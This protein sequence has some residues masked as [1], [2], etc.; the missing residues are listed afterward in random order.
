MSYWLKPLFLKL[1]D[2]GQDISIRIAHFQVF[3]IPLIEF[4]IETIEVDS[5]LIVVNDWVDI[6]DRI[7]FRSIKSNKG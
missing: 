1:L 4:A 5:G 6:I 7:Q 3:L 2:I